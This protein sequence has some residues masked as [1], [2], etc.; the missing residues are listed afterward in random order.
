MSMKQSVVI[1]NEYTIR[2]KAGGGSRGGSPGMYVLRYMARNGATEGLTP[3][4]LG[5]ENFLDRYEARE[6]ITEEA[7]SIDDLKAGMKD[8]QG[9]GGVGFG[10]GKYSLS[11]REIRAAAKDIQRNFDKGK[12]V[13]KTVLSFDEE[14]LRK[15]GIIPEDFEYH[16][17]GDYRG[18]IDQ[19]KLR[20]AIM[21][22]L[23]KMSKNY[24][25]LQ[26]IGVIQVD[27]QHIHCHLA[28]V[29]RGRGNLA[30]DGTQRGKISERSKN[31]LRK[32]IDSFLAEKQPVKMMSANTEYDRR[33]TICFVKKYTHRLID[34][35]GFTQFLLACLPDD[36][37][38]WRSD[39][40]RQDMQ[41]PN[42]IVREYVG[43][44][45]DMPNSGYREALEQVDQ[46]AQSRVRQDNLTGEEYRRIY[47]DGQA[48]IINRCMDA[49]YSV[50][51]QI[52]KSEFDV[53]TPL[54]ETMAMPYEDMASEADSDPM[55][56][57]GFKL[58]SYKSRL[59]H[60]RDERH[61]YH[62]AARD[63]EATMRA[64]EADVSSRPLYDFFRFEEE[65]NAMLMSKYQHFLAF[66][67]PEEEYMQ[68]FQDILDYED[69][70][71]KMRRMMADR[72]MK[73]MRATEAERYG[74]ETYGED[75]GQYVVTRPAYLEE[76]ISNMEEHLEEMRQDYRLHLADYGMTVGEDGHPVRTEE[77]DFE[78]VK[79][80]DLH[81]LMFDFP[82]DFAISNDYAQQFVEMADRRY[83]LFQAAKAYLE[84]TGQADAVSA[85]PA[86]DVETQHREADRFRDEPVLYTKREAAKERRAQTHTISID[87]SFYLDREE[88]IKNLVQ[89]VVS[90]LQYGI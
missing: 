42:A 86:A 60:H 58:R 61:R 30:A 36:R 2:D 20:M 62:D 31:M 12:T 14:Y 38:V 67:P 49:V 28:M 37:S 6:E 83:E 40:D 18:N 64:G 80:L 70:I 27:T 52:P 44:L 56:E 21:N 34:E 69:R 68:G 47:N 85:L 54:M 89:N 74:L 65:Y 8:V 87:S 79:A 48:H 32:G 82:Y 19:L 77:Y 35:R 75:G 1:V 90:D 59:D 17:L 53:R 63:Y 7:L 76:R 39:T 9:Y 33:N 15:Y 10:Y 55:I 43:Q 11:D 72:D 29:D 5:D 84:A 88:E 71:R 24:D 45:L 41:K 13:L 25:D 46:Y 50:L 51:E 3:I 16:A 73:R 57:F 78:D 22:G 26:Y 4:R 66:I 81:H 23:D